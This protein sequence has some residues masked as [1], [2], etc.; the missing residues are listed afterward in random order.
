LPLSK[1]RKPRTTDIRGRGGRRP[2]SGR[3]KGTANKLDAEIRQK[4]AEEGIL[5]V[6]YMLKVMR[7]ARVPKA[8]RDAMAIAAAPYL[9]AKLSSVELKNKKGEALRLAT[10]D[11]SAKE[12]ADAFATT[13]SQPTFEDDED[14]T[15]H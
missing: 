5:P 13:L 10:Q 12:A 9:H 11:M 3:K 2:G 14:V 7:D 4:A 8:R 6:Q 15:R 1:W